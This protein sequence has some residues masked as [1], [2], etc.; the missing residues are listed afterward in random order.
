M[1]V[2]GSG[3]VFFADS[4]HHAVVRLDYADPPSLT[5]GKTSVGVESSDSPQ[6]V[7]VSNNGNADLTFPVPASGHNPSISSGFTLDVLTTCPELSASSTAG[8]LAAGASCDYAVDFIPVA[9]QP[10]SGSLTLTDNSLNASPAVTQAIPLT[11]NGP[12]LAFTT[13]PPASQ[14]IGQGPGTV[15]VS[16]E[17]F[18]NHV[19]TTSSATVTLT[20][21]GPNWYFA[22]YTA[23][24]SSGIATFSSLASLTTVGSYSYTATDIPDGLAKAVATESVVGP[25]LAFTTPP[26]ASQPFGQGPGTVAVSVEDS[27]S[28][29]VTTSS[30]TVTLTVAGPGGG[31]EE[32]TATASSGIATFS[33]IAELGT[34]GLYIYTATDTRDGLTPA[35]ATE[36][37][38]VPHLAFTTPPPSSLLPGH[39]PG[40]VAISVQDPNNHV[41]TTSSATVTL[42]VTGPN[43]YSKVYTATA[44][45]GIATFSSLASLSTAGIYTYTATDPPDRLI[46]AIAHESVSVPHLV[47]TSPPPHSLSPGQSPGTVAVSVQDPNNNVM[48]TSSATVTL[49]VTG[50]SSYS[51][52]Y[53]ATASR[54]IATFS[55]LASLTTLG[56]YSYTATDAPDGFP[57]AVA[58]ETVFGPPSAIS[59]SP[60]S[61]LGT[62]QQFSFM[63]SSPNGAG[64]LAFVNMMFNTIGSQVNGCYLTYLAAG[65]QLTLL[66]DDHN[67]STS[68]QPGA[69]GTLNNSQCSVNLSAT[70][71]S[72]SGNTLT[73]AAH[74]Y[75]SRVRL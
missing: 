4:G 47:F 56:S 43:S 36:S 31:Y 71:V 30:A 21:T 66:S 39:G 17:D 65:N 68:G 60:S 9:A 49:T 62:T 22:V 19:V 18:F 27:S 63:A 28:K 20:V 42:T 12:H 35:V 55:S 15:A 61:G 13:P 64:N 67:T 32:Y 58:H 11:G 40:T 53:T 33:S 45:S 46:H 51:K 29:V 5:F 73:L 2:D 44:S 8:T 38:F 3:N 1:A 23:T 25:H 54:G 6:T 72:A 59:V 7:T 24:A 48:T 75:F 16:V 10:Y 52:V 50:P 74:H 14:P 26:P 69:T 70:T 57:Q 41:I 34:A 37:V